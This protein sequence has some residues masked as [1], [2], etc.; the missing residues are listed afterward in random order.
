MNIALIV[1]SAAVVISV[2][3]LIST[4]IWNR[5]VSRR[6][7][8]IDLLWAEQTDKTSL[9]MRAQ[10]LA[11]VKEGRLEELSEREKWFSPESFPL[12]SRMN[13]YEIAAIGISEGTIDSRIFKRYWRTA[14]V[15]DWVRCKAAATKQRNESDNP[16][17][18]VEWEKLAKSWANWNE[19]R[20]L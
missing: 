19:A 17:L 11:L 20:E 5:I 8:T 2:I 15:R 4:I 9:E 1:Q 12:V 3:G 6:K 16:Q 13:R 14:L 7:T 18:Y 10:Y